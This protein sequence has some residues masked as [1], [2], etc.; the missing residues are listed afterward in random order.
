MFTKICFSLG[1]VLGWAPILI[2]KMSGALATITPV[3]PFP[4][5]IDILSTVKAIYT[6]C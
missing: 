2:K 6:L 5:N 4:V 1:V 3:F